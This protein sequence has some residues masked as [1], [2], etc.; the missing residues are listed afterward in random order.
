LVMD[1]RHTNE[2]VQTIFILSV[3][4]VL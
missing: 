4:V 2:R 3:D 1:E